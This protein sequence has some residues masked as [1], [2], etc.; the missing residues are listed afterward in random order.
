M[1]DFGST[2]YANINAKSEANWILPFGH[3][4]F[5]LDPPER[6]RFFGADVYS[7]GKTIEYYAKQWNQWNDKIASIVNLMVGFSVVV[8]ILIVILSKTP[9]EWEDRISIK[10]A[11]QRFEEFQ[12]K[13]NNENNN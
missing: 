13:G 9:T 6:H 5:M 12:T 11:R 10:E 4:G 2:Y 7:A 1:I 3:K 8:L